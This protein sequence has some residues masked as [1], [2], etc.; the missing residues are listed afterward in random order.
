MHLMMN[1]SFWMNRFK[2]RLQISTVLPLRLFTRDTLLT[3][4]QGLLTVDAMGKSVGTVE[5][6]AVSI[7]P[8]D[9]LLESISGFRWFQSL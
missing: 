1:P 3:K 7:R 2:S 4:K 9:R 5:K 6:P 8:V